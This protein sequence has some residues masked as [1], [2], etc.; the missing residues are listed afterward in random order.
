MNIFKDIVNCITG[1]QNRVIIKD[2]I[3]DFL[4][5]EVE[6]GHSASASKSYT[7][8][9]TRMKNTKEYYENSRREIKN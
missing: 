1:G 3:Y 7:L 5:T 9:R 2:A 8:Y 6:N 4:L